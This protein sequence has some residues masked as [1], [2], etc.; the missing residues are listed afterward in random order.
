LSRDVMQARPMPS[1]DDCPSVTFVNSVKTSNR[2][3]NF[4]S[5]SGSQTIPIFFR[6][7]CH[8]NI[9]TGTPPFNEGVKCRWGR[10]KSRLSKNSWLSIDC[11]TW[12]TMATDDHAVSHRQRRISLFLF[13]ISLQHGRIRR[14]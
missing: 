9:P 14:R 10:H 5:P 2:I 1:C 3:F 11:W 4:F 8:D 13:I 12:A 7:K 6:T